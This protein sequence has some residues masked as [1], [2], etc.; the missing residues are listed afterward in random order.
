[1]SI[2]VVVV[3]LGLLISLSGIS[4]QMGVR[5]LS[6]SGHE[7]AVKRALHAADAAI[8]AAIFRLNRADL[9]G[10]LNVDPVHP[11][12]FTSQTCVV[13]TGSVGG[14]DL[15]QLPTGS[16]VDPSGRR[17]C[18]ATEAETTDSGA[19]FRYRVSEAARAGTG[20]CGTAHAVSLDRR[21]VATGRSGNVTRRVTATLQANIALL[22]GA[23]VQSGSASSPLR[24]NGTSRVLGRIQSNGNIIGSGANVV[25]GSAIPGPGHTATGVVATT[26]TPSCQP[27]ALPLVDSVSASASNNNPASGGIPQRCLT[28]GT[29]VESSVCSVLGLGLQGGSEWDA[30]KRT[31]RVWGTGIVTLTGSQYSFCSVRLEGSAVLKVPNSTPVSRIFVDDPANCP[32]VA[33]AGSITVDGQARIVNCHQLTESNTLQLYALGSQSTATTQTLA[34]AGPFS[35][36]GMSAVCGLNVALV[37]A[38]MIVYA[39]RSAL[40][41]GGSTAISGIVAADAVTMSGSAAVH[42]VDSLINLNQLGANPSLPLYHPIDYVECGGTYKSFEELPSSDPSK[43]C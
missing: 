20:T 1:M 4:L 30:S 38:P 18:P 39:P 23:A 27:F 11:E 19:S 3:T 31:L 17:W 10:A 32:G 9:G 2:V 28:S 21:I 37:G 5:A 15:T 13:S 42:P 26:T 8:D 25:T 29:L 6:L 34:G 24:L 36:T 16:G 33:S 35:A 43:G 14:I 12:T 22:S 40:A 7:A 41:I